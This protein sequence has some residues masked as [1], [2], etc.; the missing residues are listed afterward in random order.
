ML[1]IVSIQTFQVKFNGSSSERISFVHD[2]ISS[3][4][5]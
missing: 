1:Q 3:T 4:S 5:I 2:F